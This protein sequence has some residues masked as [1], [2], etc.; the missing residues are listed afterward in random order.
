MG[1]KFL[2]GC[3]R[4]EVRDRSRKGGNGEGSLG[5]FEGSHRKDSCYVRGKIKKRGGVG[6]KKSLFKTAT[7]KQP[8]SKKREVGEE[9][10]RTKRAKR[11]AS[12]FWGMEKAKFIR[13]G[14]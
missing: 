5:T 13:S 2:L 9:P 3:V 7:R 4:R 6:V 14:S 10:H 12:R 1:E 8:R 11:R